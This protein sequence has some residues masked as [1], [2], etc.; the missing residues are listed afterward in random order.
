MIN[1]PA[2]RIG[3]CSWSLRPKS[4]HE[5]AAGLA[6]LGIP[7]V[8]LALDPIRRG[9]PGWGEIETLNALRSAG[10]TVLSGMIG[11]KSEDYTTIESIRRTGG[12]RPDRDWGENIRAADAAARLARRLGI[13]LVTFHAGFIPEEPGADRREMLD[14]VRM[15][16]D[17]FDDQSVRIGLETGQ[18]SAKVL[19]EALDEL[20][21]PHV[22]INFDPANMLLYGMGDTVE[23][24]SLLTRRIVQVHIKDAHPGDL[25]QWGQEVRAGDGAVDWGRLFDTLRSGGF[26]GDLVIERES[27]KH[28][29]EPTARIEDILAARTLLERHGFLPSATDQRSGRP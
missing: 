24:A 5:L 29:A 10:V 2:N 8:Q 25:R 20:N 15:V 7:N 11:M 17:R 14:R 6:R 13:G 27:L 26:G 23:A 22:G 1:T 9:D 18:E 16:V 12:V 28:G 19:L 4:A 21:R 3:V